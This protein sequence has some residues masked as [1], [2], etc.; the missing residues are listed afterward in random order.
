MPTAKLDPA[1][2]TWPARAV[3]LALV[4]GG[5]LTIGAV[6]APGDW[7]AALNKPWF[8]PPGWLF[9][10][11]WTVLYVLIAMMGW[12][13]YAAGL[14]S[15][16]MRLWWGQLALNFFWSPVFFSLQRPDLALLVIL[17]LLVTLVMLL[18]TC[19]SQ[20]RPSALALLPYLAWVSFASLL[21]LSIF[22]L[23]P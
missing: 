4:I 20:D 19:W 10:P 12:R 1:R 23:N 11:V 15:R 16:R 3:F 21:N 5:G 8:N 18:R 13:A 17:G 2:I 6:T 9:A 7:Y 22:I 14:S